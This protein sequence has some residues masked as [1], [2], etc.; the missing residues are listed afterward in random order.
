MAKGKNNTRKNDPKKAYVDSIFSKLK[1]ENM[2]D[3]RALKEMSVDELRK[4]SQMSPEE[5]QATWEVAATAKQ[6]EIAGQKLPEQEKK[7]EIK[8][9]VQQVQQPQKEETKPPVQQVQQPKKEIPAENKTVSPVDVEKQK[10]LDDLATKLGTS[11]AWAAARKRQA[12]GKSNHL[13]TPKQSTIKAAAERVKQSPAFQILEG[14]SIQELQQLNEM[15]K[16]TRTAIWDGYVEDIKKEQEQIKADSTLATE[17]QQK[18]IQNTQQQPKVEQPVK[19]E[20]TP[21]VEETPK[22]EITPPANVETKKVEETK[23]EQPKT[24]SS[25]EFTAQYNKLQETMAS[26]QQQMEELKKLNPNA[27]PQQAAP[28][29]KA[30][31]KKVPEQK[32]PEKKAPQKDV[33]KPPERPSW[34]KEKADNEI[35]VDNFYSTIGTA[36]KGIKGTKKTTYGLEKFSAAMKAFNKNYRKNLENTKETRK[37]LGN[38]LKMTADN[39][40]WELAPALNEA[41]RYHRSV[42][43]MGAD[44]GKQELDNM[45]SIVQLET[46]DTLAANNIT[47]NSREG[48]DILLASKVSFA[49]N[50]ADLMKSLEKHKEDPLDDSYKQRLSAM[51]NPK[52]MQLS[53]KAVYDNPSFKKFLS[54]MDEKAVRSLLE[55]PGEEI[56]KAYDT[57]RRENLEATRVNEEKKVEQPVKVEQPQQEQSGPAV[58]Y[59]VHVTS[60]H[61]DQARVEADALMEKVPPLK[62]V[63][64]AMVRGNLLTLALA[65]SVGRDAINSIDMNSSTAKEDLRK[66]LA[67]IMTLRVIQEGIENN[68][69]DFIKALDTPDGLQKM[70][71]IIK[72][73]NDFRDM[74]R[75]DTPEAANAL[76]NNP[77]KDKT[78]FLSNIASRLANR[79]VKSTATV[80]KTQENKP[81]MNNLQENKPKHRGMH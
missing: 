64:P 38:A 70:G 73:N 23:V 34:V 36:I 22:V 39:F 18:E 67:D 19:V 80:N 61:V 74:T 14:K 41:K 29:K 43:L 33:P 53:M 13:K 1:L 27:V 59:A 47:P 42:A 72:E 66:S 60:A 4:M 24:L 49:L 15:D 21:K 26:L 71:K 76:I 11:K 32:A 78:L 10:L 50:R 9:P 58:S 57:F 40:R 12:A 68:N 51:C 37:I 16:D 30:P 44:V 2:S 63:T 45:A 69:P 56:K 8:P 6:A 20:Q 77:P 81:Q 25:A 5:L 54:S 48:L 28:E 62:S 35:E 7:E 31:E 52:G 55:K 65:A 79:P 3:Y 17:E 75:V 46:M